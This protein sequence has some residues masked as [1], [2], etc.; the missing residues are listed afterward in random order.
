MPNPYIFPAGTQLY[1]S[2]AAG[3]IVAPPTVA[4]ALP[5]SFP[6]SGGDVGTDPETTWVPF[7][8]VKSVAGL[9]QLVPETT[10]H[11]CINSTAGLIEKIGT[12]FFTPTTVNMKLS[13]D[14]A[15]YTFFDGLVEDRDVI[16]ML[17][18]FPTRSDHTSPFRMA[19]R[20]YVNGASIN[21]DSL[22]EEI[23]TDLTLELAFDSGEKVL[24]A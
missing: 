8:C 1:Y 14:Q 15:E 12:G 21:L 16:R 22:T 11:R 3:H 2:H 10:E 5:T 24:G 4:T 18:V 9:G 6:L 20:Y 7:G 19:F 23:A 17:I 13:F